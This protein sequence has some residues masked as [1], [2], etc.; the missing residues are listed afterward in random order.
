M[1]FP[2]STVVDVTKASPS[3]FGILSPAATVVEDSSTHW[4]SGFEYE[5]LDCG[6]SAQIST[7]C[8]GTTPVES[9]APDPDAE[10]WESYLPFAV[11]VDF[12]CTTL[13]MNGSDYERR[14]L[15]RLQACQQKVIEREFWTGEL[16]R[17]EQLSD[18]N[19]PNRFLASTGATDLTPSAGVAIKPKFGLALLEDA[20]GSCGCGVTG[21][22]HMTRGTASSLGIAASDAVLKTPLGNSVIA[23]AGYDGSGP[24]NVLPSGTTRWMYAT[25]PLTV[26][27]SAPEV[28][29]TESRQFVDSSVNKAT[30]HA[31]RVAAVT[32]DTCCHYGVL[33]D[34]SLDYS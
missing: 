4:T 2:R 17:K 11:E 28:R 32:W 19:F 31:D 29:A 9:I 20:L 10:P 27:L 13:G 21:T 12:S 18:E 6:T 30:L 24:D 7:I 1:A 8:T 26:R 34:L 33:V 22:V 15:D 25:G 5:T 16:A 3:S 14:A 23:G